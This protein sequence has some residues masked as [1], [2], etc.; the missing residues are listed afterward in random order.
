M[1]RKKT[2]AASLEEQ[3]MFLNPN[4]I[5]A[6]PEDNIRGGLPSDAQI[7][8][9]AQSIKVQGQLQ[10]V[11][12]RPHPT[13]D[14]GLALAYG[15]TRFLAVKYL[16]AHGM[17]DIRVKAVPV[18]V[19]HGLDS[20]TTAFLATIAENAHRRDTTPMEDARGLKRLTDP[21]AEGGFGMSQVEASKP[22]G[23]NQAWVSRTLRLLDLPEELQAKVQTGDIPAA[24][25]LVLAQYGDAETF[26]AAAA[27][28]ITNIEQ[29]R[30]AAR[31]A[32][33]RREAQK[34]SQAE[35]EESDATEGGEAADGSPESGNGT[36]KSAKGGKTAGK[37]KASKKA[38]KKAT[39]RPLPDSVPRSYKELKVWLAKAAKKKQGDPLR[40]IAEHLLA[41]TKGE[42][43][44]NGLTVKVR[45][46]LRS[47]QQ[48]GMEEPDTDADTGSDTGAGESPNNQQ[49][50][51]GN[52]EAATA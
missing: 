52:E 29:A 32:Q 11:G 10:P 17:P 49:V 5:D 9:M 3:L 1:A 35:D 23:Q 14:S 4:E 2:V 39:G 50:T 26:A 30:E 16:A 13:K 45:K 40:E 8:A 51:S 22:F 19:I 34:A 18:P 48:D 20:S 6:R 28:K 36:S 38:K 25:G 33:A 12:V 41:Y 47:I 43:S 24:A 27:G 7:K 31:A 42:L 44:D 37:G 46:V 21:I 15:F